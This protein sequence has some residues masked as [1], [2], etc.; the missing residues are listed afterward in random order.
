VIGR[1]HF[2][3][4]RLLIRSLQ[5]STS[6]QILIIKNGRLG[7]WL[8]CAAPTKT[9]RLLIRRVGLFQSDH[10][11]DIVGD[12]SHEAG[13]I[14]MEEEAQAIAKAAGKDEKEVD[15]IC[16]SIDGNACSNPDLVRKHLNSGVLSKMITEK[17]AIMLAMP[18]RE[19]GLEFYLQDP[20][21]VY[22][23]LGACAMTLGC[24]LSGSY[25]AMLKKVYTE[26]GLMPDALKQMKKALN[27]PNGYKNGEPYDFASKSLIETADLIDHQDEQ[28][29]KFD[30]FG[31][32]V[33]VRVAC[34]TQA[35]GTLPLQ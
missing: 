5:F 18:T 26:G 14:K 25:V 3:Q 12:L 2:L 11:L 20:C 1:F 10:D 16:Y 22:V 9:L 13:L 24:H 15:G 4:R 27:G 30:F 8:V 32:N 33:L 31:M 19:R 21:Y 29:N 28:S 7:I 34:S 17:E 6:N 23:L 35:W